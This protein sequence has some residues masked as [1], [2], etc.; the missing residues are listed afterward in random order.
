MPA[1]NSDTPATGPTLEDAARNFEALLDREDG[2]QPAE[3]QAAE[4]VP[5][6]GDVADAPPEETPQ[7]GTGEEEAAEPEEGAEEAEPRQTLVPVVIDGKTQELPL[8]EV[9]KGY[10]RQADYTRKTTE[11]ASQR[12]EFEAQVQAVREEREQYQTMLVKLREQID[13]AGEQEPDWDEVYRTDPIGYAR[14]RDE[15]RDRQ[16][17]VAAAHF[18]LQRLHQL[19]QQEQAAALQK[20]VE[21]GAVKMR[22]MY[23][24]WKDQK[25][26]DADREKLVAYLTSPGVG[27]TTEEIGQA[28][29]PRAVVLSNKARMWDEMMANKPQPVQRPGPRVASAGAVQPSGPSSRLNSAQQRLARSGSLKDA[30][31]VWEHLL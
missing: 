29:D 4:G 3:D 24:A 9:A 2:T 11:L 18:E 23:P 28:Y 30:A 14:K 17:K 5:T 22:D 1:T 13:T 15:W 20:T 19:K 27:Y 25:T 26:W 6:P 10:Q 7:P 12:R 8:E 21:Q 16:D 31:K